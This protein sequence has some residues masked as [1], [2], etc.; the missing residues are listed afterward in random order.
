MPWE[1]L[2]ERP[3]YRPLGDA[4]TGGLFE[5]PSAPR[6]PDELRGKGCVRVD[7]PTGARWL[8]KKLPRQLYLAFVHG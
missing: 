5:G 8:P 6:A 4:L 7:K 1:S 2:G 3:T